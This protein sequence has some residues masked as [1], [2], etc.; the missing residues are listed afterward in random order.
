[1]IPILAGIAVTLV[2]A[3]IVL[4]AIFVPKLLSGTGSELECPNFVGKTLE[5]I[6]ANEEYT[7]NF[8][9]EEEWH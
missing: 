7:T 9:F 2:I 3:I 4:A 5:E 1:M 6:K 8:N